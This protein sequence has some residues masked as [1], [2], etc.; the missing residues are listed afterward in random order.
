MFA[1]SYEVRKTLPPPARQLAGTPERL[2]HL[3]PGPI[4]R[5]RRSRGV[6]PPGSPIAAT[7]PQGKAIRLPPDWAKELSANNAL[8]GQASWDESLT[9]GVL[10]VAV[11][12]ERGEGPMLGALAAR[13]SLR[14]AQKGL[15]ASLPGAARRF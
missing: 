10:V 13:L 11:P 8:V 4:E 3:G 14:G 2:S 9:K 5:V 1:S 15:R 6:P 12:V 7:S